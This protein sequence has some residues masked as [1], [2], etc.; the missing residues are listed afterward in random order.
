MTVSLI[1]GQVEP[2]SSEVINYKCSNICK[3]RGIKLI[4]SKS[5]DTKDFEI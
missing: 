5:I 2:I 4:E 3:E 1:K